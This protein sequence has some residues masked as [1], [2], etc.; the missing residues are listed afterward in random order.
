MMYTFDLQ[1]NI[2]FTLPP[3]LFLFER[4]QISQSLYPLRRA[5]S[6]YMAHP[7][8]KYLPNVS[9]YQFYPPS[10]HQPLQ[11]SFRFRP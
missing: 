8:Y 2:L 4:H 11:Q 6:P 3:L 9:H 1:A 5:P 10:I 7:S